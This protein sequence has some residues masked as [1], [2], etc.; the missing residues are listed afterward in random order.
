MTKKELLEYEEKYG[1]IPNDRDERLQ[2][3]MSKAKDQDRTFSSVPKEIERIRKIKW[4]TIKYVIYLIP[5][6]SP[7]PRKS[8]NGHFYVNGAADNKRFFKNF[9]KETL[10]TPIIDT[11]CKFYCD[12]YLPIPNDM[13]LVNQ[14]LAELGLI[15]P[16]KKPDFDNLA[17]TYSDM[18]QGILLFD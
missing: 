16:L 7:R 3:I 10:D 1:S 9:Y 15:R 8:M 14:F 12:S 5:K 4:K 2:F 17:K 6:A 11:P 13:S 18:T